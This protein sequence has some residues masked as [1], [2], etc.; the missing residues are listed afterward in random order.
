MSNTEKNLKIGE[1][2]VKE[3]LHRLKG[4]DDEALANKIAR[5]AISAITGQ[6]SAL[7]GKVIDDEQSVE[8]AQEA[9]DNATYPVSMFKDSKTYCQQILK[10]QESLNDAQ[11]ELKNT[12]DSIEFFKNLLTKF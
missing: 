12:K 1:L 4:N 11:A 10:A 6:I 7:E 3:V 5:K 8:D 9:L 2:F